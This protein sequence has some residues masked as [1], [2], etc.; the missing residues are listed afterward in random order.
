[1]LSSWG[2][3]IF[4]NSIKNKHYEIEIPNNRMLFSY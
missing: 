4:G 2:F 3:F 1:M